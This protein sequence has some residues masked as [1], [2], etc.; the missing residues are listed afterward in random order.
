MAWL[1]HFAES[2]PEEKHILMLNLFTIYSQL[3]H[4]L[5]ITLRHTLY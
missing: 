5:N 4:P 2:A 3:M 1:E